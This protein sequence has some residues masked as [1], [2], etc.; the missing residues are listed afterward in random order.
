MQNVPKRIH[1]TGLFERYLHRWCT[2]WCVRAMRGCGVWWVCYDVECV[3][4]CVCEYVCVCVCVCVR[5]RARVCVRARLKRSRPAGD[6][7]AGSPSR[8]RWISRWIESRPSFFIVL[9]LG[10][11]SAIHLARSRNSCSRPSAQ[12][13]SKSFTSRLSHFSRAAHATEINQHES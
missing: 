5:A 11:G 9:W 4:V 10:P 6:E 12:H 2:C 8:D 7:G 13:S 1:G 3:R